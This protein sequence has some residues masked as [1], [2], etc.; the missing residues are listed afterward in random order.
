LKRIVADSV[1]LFL[2]PSRLLLK[3][4][5]FFLNVLKKLI[6]NNTQREKEAFALLFKC[7]ACNKPMVHVNN[8]H[9]IKTITRKINQIKKKLSE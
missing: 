4:L 3:S 6:I 5:N 7:P 2:N 8:G 9:I 1:H